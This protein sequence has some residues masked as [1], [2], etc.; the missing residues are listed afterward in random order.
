MNI[1]F[2]HDGTCLTVILAGELDHHTAAAVRGGIDE[3]MNLARPKKL[4]LD[5]RN[6]TF[7]DSSGVG[8]TM[9]RYRKIVSMGGKLIIRDPPE[10]I[11]RM[12]AMSGIEKIAQIQQTKEVFKDEVH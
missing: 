9:G 10:H 6:V 11:R 3:E 2:E 7:M 12:F 4:I 5:F 1:M 8:L